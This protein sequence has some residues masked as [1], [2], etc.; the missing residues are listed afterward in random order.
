M[1]YRD[2]SSLGW[3]S[4][5]L[6]IRVRLFSPSPQFDALVTFLLL[7]GAAM[8]SL[9]MLSSATSAVRSSLWNLN[10]TCRARCLTFWLTR[11][12]WAHH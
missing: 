12:L 10:C 4:L 6:G 11:C 7:S 9:R 1:N 3:T 2:Y 8:T 5:Y